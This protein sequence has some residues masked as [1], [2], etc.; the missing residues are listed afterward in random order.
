MVSKHRYLQSKIEILDER[1]Y[2]ACNTTLPHPLQKF[3][4]VFLTIS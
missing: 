2:R 1:G 3:L 4:S